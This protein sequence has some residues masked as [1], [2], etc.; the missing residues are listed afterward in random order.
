MYNKYET[1]QYRKVMEIKME[2]GRKEFFEAI[3]DSFFEEQSVDLEGFKSMVQGAMP[4]FGTLEVV[5]EEGEKIGKTLTFIDNDK[6]DFVIHSKDVNLDEVDTDM[7]TVVMKL[8]LDENCII[9]TVS[10][11]IG[12]FFT[13]ANKELV[14]L[15]ASFIGKKITFG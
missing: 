12:G 10:H 11:D 2:M 1:K 5:M 8:T 6:A 7:S 15:L 4:I 9:K 3:R 13:P 14:L